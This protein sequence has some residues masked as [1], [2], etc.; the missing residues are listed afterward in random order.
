MNSHREFANGTDNWKINVG[1][2]DIVTIL[3]EMFIY[4]KYRKYAVRKLVF[5]NNM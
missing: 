1:N 3:F 5:H 2:A 4:N